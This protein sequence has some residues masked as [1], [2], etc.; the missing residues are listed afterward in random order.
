[1]KSHGYVET[2]NVSDSPSR[3]SNGKE[4]LELQNKCR[5]SINISVSARKVEMAQIYL[6]IL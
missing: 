3:S 1:M 5:F 4:F 2:A 6:H